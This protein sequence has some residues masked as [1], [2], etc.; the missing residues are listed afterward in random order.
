[1]WEELF[2]SQINPCVFRCL[3]C[4]CKGC[5]NLQELRNTSRNYINYF[6]KNLSINPRKKPKC[7]EEHIKKY[8]NKEIMN[9]PK[10][11]IYLMY[12]S[13]I[14]Y[15]KP[16]SGRV[17]VVNFPFFSCII[18]SH[19]SVIHGWVSIVAFN[20]AAK[21]WKIHNLVEIKSALQILVN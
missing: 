1:M 11:I 7:R 5:L 4:E 17:Q 16:E 12:V 10:I 21:E 18:E 3:V 2:F 6:I 15:K 13:L 8:K 14:L 19:W 20:D 9:K